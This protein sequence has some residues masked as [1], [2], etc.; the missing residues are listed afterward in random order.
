MGFLQ[1]VNSDEMDE[2]KLARLWGNSYPE[3]VENGSKVIVHRNEFLIQLGEDGIADIITEAGG[4]IYHSDIESHPDKDIYSEVIDEFAKAHSEFFPNREF[5]V[6]SSVQKITSP[7]QL[8]RLLLELA[9]EY[10]P[11]A[12]TVSPAEPTKN[13]KWICKCDT[14]NDH[15]FCK[16]CGSPRLSDSEV[17]TPPKTNIPEPAPKTASPVMPSRSEEMWICGECGTKN[18]FSYCKNCGASRQHDS[19]IYIDPQTSN[20]TWICRCGTKNEFSFC[21]NCGSSRPM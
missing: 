17:Y 14:E 1:V 15:N 2:E 19:E 16:S 12:A 20:N 4:Y 9:G 21:K 11:S 10:V 13:E 7:E 6:V 5:A 18:K 8:N 3:Q